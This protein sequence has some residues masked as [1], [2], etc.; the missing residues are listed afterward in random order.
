MY[1]L[2]LAKGLWKYVDGSAALAEDA[3]ERVCAEVPESRVYTAKPQ[4]YR[5]TSCET[6]KY[7]W[8]ALRRHFERDTLSNKLKKQYFRKEMNEGTSKEA[9]LIEMKELTTNC[10]QLEL[11]SQKKTKLLHY[12]LP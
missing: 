2:L 3:D 12:S 7:I 1:H 9:H 4:V 6:P 10:H 11:Q 8:D 5:V